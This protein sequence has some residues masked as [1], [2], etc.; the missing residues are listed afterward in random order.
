M[1]TRAAGDI[2]VLDSHT[3]ELIKNIYNKSAQ[4]VYVGVDPV[5]FKN[6]MDTE[7]CSRYKNYEVIL[8][9]S[10]ALNPVKGT[11]YVVQAMPLIIKKIPN[12]RLLIMNPLENEREKEALIKYACELGVNSHIEFLPSL[13][14]DAIP[15][16]LSM[17]KVVIQPSV[18]SCAHLPIIEAAACETPAIAFSGISE[19]DIIDGQTGF[20]IPQG[21]ITLL[22]EKAIQIMNNAELN[23]TM[24]EK[25]RKMAENS[26]SW[27][28]QASTMWSIIQKLSYA[29]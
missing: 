20:I 2:I 24:G 13:D 18:Y 29:S 19:E 11:R 22:A 12:C 3:A 14:D 5:F 25:A 15:R 21:N 9:S 27:D 28:T 23:K 17:A 7:L 8:H 1:A 26:F 6:K 10:T 4:P 16:Y